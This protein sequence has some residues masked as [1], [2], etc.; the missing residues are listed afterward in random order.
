MSRPGVVVLGGGQA[1]FTVVDALRRLGYGE[2]V[3][4]VEESTD[5]PYQ[6]PPLSKAYLAGNL[7]AD[8]LAFRPMSY[9]RDN[10]V[11]LVL[12]ERITRLDHH[13]HRVVLSSGLRI[14]YQ[15][16]VVATGSQVREWPG[17]GGQLRGVYRLHDRRDAD[18]LREGLRTSEQVVII[19]GGFIGLEFAAV[20]R[21]T[22][23]SVKVI[24]AAPRVMQRA[25]SPLASDALTALHHEHGVE[26]RCTTGVRRIVGQRRATGV[27]LADGTRL[28][29]DLV[30]VGIGSVPA[31]GADALGLI[32]SRD[33]AITV[34]SRM[35][36]SDPSVFACGDTVSFQKDDRWMR[37]ES[38]Q[39]ATDQA[40]CAANAIVGKGDN[41]SAVPWFWTE[42]YGTKLQIAGLVDRADQWTV[43]GDL[44]G[45]RWTIFSFRDG[46]LVGSESFGAV[47]DHMATRTLLHAHL[48][49]TAD[50][51]AD[52]GFDLR[53]HAAGAQHTRR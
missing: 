18:A 16:L 27:E 28:P 20:A 2:Q 49:L 1:G 6:R 21:K 26:I 37:L 46:E 25:T 13:A 33:G 23:S 17:D 53:G 48:P 4:L 9:Y 15:H 34:D 7:A 12:G 8:D 32:G 41:Y 43:R 44:G 40:R 5:L 30:L 51:A 38:I 45:D 36:T 3:V 10:E 19:G 31:L 47:G 29:A 35:R 14:D 39:N 42:Q 52:P 24:E 22:G 50:E 11:D